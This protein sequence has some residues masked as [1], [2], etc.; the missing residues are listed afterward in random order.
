MT[1]RVVAPEF[2]SR[3]QNV[4]HNAWKSIFPVSMRK[5]ISAASK[6]NLINLFP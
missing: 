5:G 3:V 2:A 6:S 1:S 4:C